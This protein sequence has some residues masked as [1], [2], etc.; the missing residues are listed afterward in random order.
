MDD[1]R[2]SKT[3]AGYT[4]NYVTQNGRVMRE[5]FRDHDLDFFYD[6]AGQPFAI[7]HYDLGQLIET[8]YCVCSTLLA[9]V[10]GCADFP[11]SKTERCSL[12]AFLLLHR[13]FIPGGCHSRGWRST[14]W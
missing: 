10:N 2:K 9:K 3:V 4:H 11:K 5:T 6:A 14:R 8:Y 1:I 7:Q 12:K 13:S